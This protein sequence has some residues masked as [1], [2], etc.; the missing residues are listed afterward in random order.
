[1]KGRWRKYRRAEKM[2]KR[3]KQ[4]LDDLQGKGIYWDLKGYTKWRSR[5]DEAVDMWQDVK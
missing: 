4:L 5:L 3:C 1:M 2:R